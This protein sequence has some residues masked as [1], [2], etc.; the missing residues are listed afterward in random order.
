MHVNTRYVNCTRGTRMHPKYVS[1]HE[2]TWYGAGFYVVHRTCQ[3]GSSFK[4]HQPC[5]NQTVLQLQATVTHLE[6]HN[7]NRVFTVSHHV[8]AQS[9]Y[10]DMRTCVRTYART[11]AHTRTLS[12]SLTHARTHAHTHTPT[13]A[14]NA[15][16]CRTQQE[17][18]E[19]ARE[20]KISP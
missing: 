4:W 5:K 10:K 1:L 9:T 16:C 2:V 19:S 8:R 3:A 18:C 7:N 15:L 13:H 6:S 12:V 17:R 14:T 20:R 11:R